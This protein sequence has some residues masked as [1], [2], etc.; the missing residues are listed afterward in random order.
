MTI[1]STKEHDY[2]L[3]NC[4]FNRIGDRRNTFY[5]CHD[6]RKSTIDVKGD[7][8]AKIVAA[9]RNNIHEAW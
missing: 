2:R 5:Y 7:S 9:D 4:A 1:G 8:S 3:H 6:V